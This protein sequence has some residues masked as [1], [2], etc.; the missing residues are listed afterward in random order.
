MKI[1][2]KFGSKVRFDKKNSTGL[3]NYSATIRIKA[4]IWSITDPV[5]RRIYAALGGDGLRPISHHR[6]ISFLFVR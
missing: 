5:H 4:I 6:I 1:S 3:V 2:P